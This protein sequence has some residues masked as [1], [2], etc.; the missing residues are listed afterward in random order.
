MTLATPPTQLRLIIE[1]DDFDR[2]VAFYRDVLGLTERP[3]FATE[4]DDRVAILEVGDATIEIATPTHT[5]NIDVIENVPASEGP[6]LRLALEVADTP[7]V[8]RASREAGIEVIAD[9][10]DTPFRSVNARVQGPAGWQVTF[11][12]ETESLDERRARPGFE[13]DDRRAR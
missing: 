8:V 12:Q 2:T 13:T 3:A 5:R 1:T 7:A 11:F 9:A 4:G 10:T 6:S